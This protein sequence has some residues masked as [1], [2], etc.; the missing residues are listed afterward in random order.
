MNP[1]PAASRDE[2]LTSA[3]RH[4]AAG[5]LD[6]AAAGYQQLHAIDRRDTDVTFLLGVLCCDLGLFEA[7]CRFLDEALEI[8]PSF[9]EARAQSIIA[10]NGLADAAVAAGDLSEA[11]RILAGILVSAPDDP[12][13]LQAL[14]RVALLRHDAAAAVDWLT[15]ALKQCPDH[16]ETLN[17]LGLAHLQIRNDA[18]AEASLRH[19][20]KLA[21]ELLQARN[22]L[23]IALHRQGKLAQARAEFETVLAQDARYLN[24]RINLANTLRIAGHA[25]DARAELERALSTNPDSV[26]ALNNL[27]AVCQ[28]L[29]RSADAVRYLDRAFALAPESAQVRWNLALS[30]LKLGD[31]SNG[32]NNFEARWE[33]CEHLRGGYR[34]PP[35][36]AWRGDSVHGR[37]V[38][39]WAEQGFGDTLQFIRFAQD[40][41]LR[42]ATVSVMAQ[43]ELVSLLRSTPG[44]STVYAEG[45]PTPDYDVHCPL[46]S[47]PHWLRVGSDRL[48]LHG[49]SPYLSA[50]PALTESWKRRLNGVPGFKVGLV[51]AGSARRQSPELAAIDARRSLPFARLAPLLAVPG[52]SFV[53]LHKE[54]AAATESHSV[55]GHATVHDLSG[56]LHD[57]SDTAAVVANLDLVVSVD[58]AVA[59]LAG[60]LGKPVWLLN[61]YDGCW[62]WLEDVSDSA[63]YRSLRQ[64]RQPRSGDWESVVAAAAAELSAVI[65]RQT[66]Q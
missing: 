38:L 14:G 62:R 31:F 57:F 21:P 27:G 13:T 33:G 19:A 60:A 24:A 66:K 15:S 53:S 49:D 35:E 29:G 43:P 22:N 65:A 26:D 10:A 17:W 7:A 58:T 5:R 55:P 39:L 54:P 34:M 47:L 36:R 8:T 18:A 16:A 9:P 45:G 1:S 37:H 20:L 40:V 61:R 48:A 41:A 6:D 28:D 63:W 3:I 59:H 11:Q 25:V 42:G 2:I 4:H 56:E 52:C 44:I 64:F 30:Q 32:W 12:A 50:D 23:G 51:W 46:M